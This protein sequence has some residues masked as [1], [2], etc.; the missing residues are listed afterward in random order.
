MGMQNDVVHTSQV[1]VVTNCNVQVVIVAACAAAAVR[2]LT[3]EPVARAECEA[4]LV[5]TPPSPS[6]A[7]RFLTL[8]G[9]S[10]GGSFLFPRLALLPPQ[11]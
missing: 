2:N 11:Q 5:V 3:D 7:P 10:G 8:R 6:P 1:R 4:C 9:R